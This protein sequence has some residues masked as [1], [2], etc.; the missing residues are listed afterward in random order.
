MEFELIVKKL[1]N[2]LSTQE[3]LAFDKWYNASAKHKA[4]YL[5]VSRSCLKNKEPVKTKEAWKIMSSKLNQ[6]SKNSDW[7]IAV[8]ATIIAVIGLSGF[9][10]FIRNQQLVSTIPNSLTSSPIEIGDDKAILTLGNGTEIVLTNKNYQN[11]QIKSNGSEII[12]EPLNSRPANEAIVYNY[13]TVPRGGEYF[14]KLSDGTKVWL[15]SDSKMKYPVRF[16]GSS[17]KVELLYGE[18]YFEVSPSTMHQGADFIVATQNQVIKVLGTE[19]NITAYKEDKYIATT[20]VGGKVTITN[21]ETQQQEYLIPNQ[22][23]KLNTKTNKLNIYNVDPENIICW[24]NGFFRFENKSLEEIMIVLSR[25]YNMEVIFKD[26]DLQKK[27]F[28]GVFSKKQQIESILGSIQKTSKAILKV[29]EDK[30][31]IENYPIQAQ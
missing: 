29:K 6:K 12:Y 27:K 10:Q 18:A 28:N 13:L 3:E 31:I 14:V 25:W 7:K 5:K 16:T 21:S 4:Y 1:K 24:K 22:Q 23:L 9:F 2:E 20:L 8:A 11:N 30:I 19:F 17:R 15:N 26:K